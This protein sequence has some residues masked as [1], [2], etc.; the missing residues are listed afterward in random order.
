MG[1]GGVEARAGGGEVFDFLDL[2]KEKRGRR[3]V[4]GS[5]LVGLMAW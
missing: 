1:R 2:Q 5:R 4:S 3:S